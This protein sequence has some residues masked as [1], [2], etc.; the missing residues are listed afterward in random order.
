MGKIINNKEDQKTQRNG[1]RLNATNNPNA[2]REDKSSISSSG[3][4]PVI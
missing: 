1:V 2:R 4:F 3:L